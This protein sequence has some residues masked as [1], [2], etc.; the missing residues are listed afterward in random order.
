[1]RILYFS[2]AYTTH[3]RRFLA[4]LAASE[5]EIAFLPLEQSPVPYE[6]RSVPNGI[7]VLDAL[8][9]GPPVTTPEE[10]LRM[11]PVFEEVV[12]QTAPDLVHSGPVQSCAFIAALAGFRPLLAMSWGSDLLVDAQRDALWNWM[13]RFTL[14]HAG[15]VVTDCDEVSQA[16]RRI[17][18]LPQHQIVQF[19]WG[20]DTAAFRPGEDRLRLREKLGWPQNRVLIS[21]RS[22]EPLYAVPQ[23]VRAFGMAHRLR[24]ALRL[25]LAGDGSQRAEVRRA[26]EECSLQGAV[27]LPGIVSQDQL[28]DYFRSADFYASFAASDGSSVS[29]LEA[30]ATGLPAIVTDRPSNREWISGDRNGILVPFGNIEAMAEAFVKYADLPSNQSAAIAANNRAVIERLAN[31]NHNF[32]RLLEAYR[33]LAPLA[34]QVT[35]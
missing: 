18:G 33:Q 20:I 13:T 31:W 32:A 21:T 14:T 5:H 10:F 34:E 3:D 7:E 11:V 1:M 27:Y 35:T 9:G 4:S 30:M 25:I 8:G 22:W 17:G 23:L 6:A 28:P 15:A 26:I 16:A 24:P 29:L 19:P 12:R 2:R